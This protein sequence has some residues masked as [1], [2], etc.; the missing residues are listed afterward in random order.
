MPNQQAELLVKQEREKYSC[1]YDGA[2]SY[3]HLACM[4]MSKQYFYAPGLWQFMS[5]GAGRYDICRL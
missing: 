2:A 1:S 5:E 4:L 3:I